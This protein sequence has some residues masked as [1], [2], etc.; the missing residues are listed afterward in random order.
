MSDDEIEL[1]VTILDTATGE[2]YQG[3]EGYWVYWWT[4]GNGS[5]DCNRDI[6]SSLDAD[7]V[8]VDDGCFACQSE[9]YLVVEVDP[10]P[11]GYTLA[12]FNKDY[13]KELILKHIGP[14]GLR[15]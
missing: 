5:H 15:R 3:A 7:S 10:M 2:R 6:G 4:Q 11:T 9:R 8:S 14:E 13:P 12:D 1:R